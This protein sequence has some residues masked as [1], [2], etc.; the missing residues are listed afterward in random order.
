MGRGIKKNKLNPSQDSQ[1]IFADTG[2]ETDGHFHKQRTEI[3][4]IA[5]TEGYSWG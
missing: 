2:A 3:P 1:E 4:G 5:G